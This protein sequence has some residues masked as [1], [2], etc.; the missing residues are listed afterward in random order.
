MTMGR[1]GYE[2]HVAVANAAAN[3]EGVERGWPRDREAIVEANALLAKLYAD[4]EM[5]Q[6][7]IDAATHGLTV[8]PDDHRLHFAMAV[9]QKRL[10][11]LAEAAR[12]FARADATF[13]ESRGE[14]FRQPGI[15]N[16]IAFFYE[17][18]KQY[19]DCARVLRRMA[20]L[21]ASTP[22]DRLV[23]SE[24]ALEATMKTSDR[25]TARGDLQKFR[26]AYRAMLGVARTPGGQAIINQSELE[27]ARYEALL[28]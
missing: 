18:Q 24:R 27:I 14:P 15:L 28:R 16:T 26:A 17:T 3:L 23:F 10:G 20:N 4:A 2:R 1:T 13:D 8:A 7:A 11:H 12:A 22:L 6:N 5:P 19:P 9:A 21:P 25:E